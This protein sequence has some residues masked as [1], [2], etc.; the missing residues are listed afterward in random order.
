MTFHNGKLCPQ[1]EPA[2]RVNAATTPSPILWGLSPA[3]IIM[4]L[5]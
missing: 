4:S 5:G 3:L 2:W 1:A